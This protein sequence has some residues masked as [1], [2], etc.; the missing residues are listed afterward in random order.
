MWFYLF[1]KNEKYPDPL[2]EIKALAKVE[3]TGEAAFLKLSSRH[4]APLKNAEEGA[5]V[6]LCTRDRGRWLVHGVAVAV[7]RASRGGTP[8]SVSSVYGATGGRHWWRRLAQ[9]HLY[10]TP[11]CE[12]DLGL[13]A[14]TLP[15]TGQSHVVHIPAP[16][17]GTTPDSAPQPASSP[18]SKLTEVMD[19][20]W[21][22]GRLTPEAVEEAVRNFRKTHPYGQ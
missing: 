2:A 19:A 9:V 7:D 10:P 5:L 14:G 21:E 18:L 4:D 12:T 13:G 16:R 6:Y 1:G 3:Q 20:A 15:A 8:L 11:R 17:N 22:G